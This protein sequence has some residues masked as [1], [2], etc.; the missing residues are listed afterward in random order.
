MMMVFFEVYMA[1]LTV[2]QDT[3]FK[4]LQQDVEYIR[5][6]F[7]LIEQDNRDLRMTANLPDS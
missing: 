1:A 4:D 7:D 3:I 5:C 2:G 6:A